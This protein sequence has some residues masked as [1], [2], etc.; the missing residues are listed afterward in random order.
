MF[1]HLAER[2]EFVRQVAVRVLRCFVL[3]ELAERFVGVCDDPG[4]ILVC[5]E[6][7]QPSFRQRK[8]EPNEA[9][10]WKR[11]GRRVA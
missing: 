9:P 5:G 11:K 10:R 8:Y 1:P 4:D 2:V 7:V 6:E 3:Q